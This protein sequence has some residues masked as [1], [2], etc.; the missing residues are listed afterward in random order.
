MG[1][2]GGILQPIYCHRFTVLMSPFA[3]LQKPL[4][5]MACAISKYKATISGAPNLACPTCIDS[6]SPEQQKVSD[7]SSWTLAYN[8]AEPIRHETLTSFAETFADAGFQLS[9]FYPCYGLAE[10][11][12]ILTGSARA[13]E[14]VNGRFHTPSPRTK[15]RPPHCRSCQQ[16]FTRQQR[17]PI[18]TEQTICIVD[19]HTLT[20][21]PDQRIREIWVAGNS[22]SPGYWQP[23]SSNSHYLPRHAC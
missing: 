5:K 10:A 1:L 4:T 12:L 16:P 13:S 20:R 23:A 22:V 3:F 7:L 9:Y 8:G 18:I 14:P 6:I 17:H 11:T 21:C 2:I 19:P 15:H